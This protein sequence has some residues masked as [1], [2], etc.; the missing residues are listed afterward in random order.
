[1]NEGNS[2]N[3]DL[4]NVSLY[5]IIGRILNRFFRLCQL[6]I[7]RLPAL[8]NRLQTTQQAANIVILAR[9]MELDEAYIVCFYV[10]ACCVF[11]INQG[12]VHIHRTDIL[13]HFRTVIDNIDTLLEISLTEIQRLE[14]QQET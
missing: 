10:E 12:R 13:Q 6:R 9:E 14:Q 7:Q 8:V 3:P 4:L 2:N 1:M 11:A 5:V